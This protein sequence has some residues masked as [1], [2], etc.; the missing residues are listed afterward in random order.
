M[1]MITV[2]IKF[3]S[4]NKLEEILVNDDRLDI[5]AIKDKPVNEWFQKIDDRNSWMGLK[6]EVCDKVAD[7]SIEIFWEI[8]APEETRNMIK[9][10]L[11]EEQIYSDINQKDGKQYRIDELRNAAQKLESR[12]QPYGIF[13]K[14]KKLADEYGDREANAKVAEYYSLGIDKKLMQDDNKAFRYYKRAAEQGDAH[15]QYCL[16]KMYESS[17]ELP[18]LEKAAMWYARAARQGINEAERKIYELNIQKGWHEVIEYLIEKAEKEE[19]KDAQEKLG[20]IYEKESDRTTAIK[21]YRKAALKGKIIP[22]E[23]L[24]GYCEEEGDQKEAFKWY[25]KRV[26]AECEEKENE[27]IIKKLGDCYYEGIGTSKDL[28]EAKKYYERY[29]Q[30][31]RDGKIFYRIGMCWDEKDCLEKAFS[32]YLK[33]AEAGDAQGQYK[34]AN[35]YCN[36]KG[37]RVNKELAAKW[38]KKSAENGYSVAQVAWGNILEKIGDEKKAFEYYFAAAR[39]GNA[40]AECNVGRFYHFGYGG[41]E[42]SYVV[43]KQWYRDACEKNNVHA[44]YLIGRL[45]EVIREDKQTAVKW[46]QKAKEID[47]QYINRCYR[48][49]DKIYNDYDKSGI[50]GWG[51]RSLAYFGVAIIMPWSNL[52]TIPMS[53]IASTA[54]ASHHCSK[55]KKLDKGKE[56]RMYYRIAAELGNEQAA[57]K[58]KFL[59]MEG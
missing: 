58:L 17:L 26:N 34:V 12:N 15:C 44:M 48:I 28:Q 25:L 51:L 40:E 38:L 50:D 19:N 16:A 9:V 52:F 30:Y 37:T 29:V 7:S 14:L 3:N 39:Q 5:E 46:Y 43:A 31:I 6:Q 27:I 57:E 24:A 54:D 23:K 32:W 56:A 42:V 10:C 47:P 8:D 4:N 21:W 18:I 53:I 49:A 59:G 45:Y 1:I 55:F 2:E 22:M 11:K 41:L 36:G 35:R 33:S 20:N 13:L